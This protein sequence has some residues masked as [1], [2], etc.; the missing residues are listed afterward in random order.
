[1]K[2]STNMKT[3]T[4]L[5]VT[6]VLNFTLFGTDADAVSKVS[7]KNNVPKRAYLTFDDGNSP[8]THEILDILNKYE[9]EATFFVLAKNAHKET[10]ERIIN[11][12]H[13]LG[14]HGY[15]HKYSIY[16]NASTL[17]ED[18]RKANDIFM[19]TVGFRPIFFRPPYG[20]RK[21][22]N[23]E[24][25]KYIALNDQNYMYVYWNGDS[26]DAIISNISPE[27]IIK[28]SIYYIEKNPNDVVLLFHDG[29]GKENTARALPVILEYL[30][31][32][33][34]EIVGFD[35][36][37]NIKSVTY[38]ALDKNFEQRLKKLERVME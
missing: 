5:L 25:R 15:S 28:Y 20:E 23:S 4:M 31:Q 1:M 22:I 3:I 10:L 19:D 16:K 7:Q 8:I 2:K 29:L 34:Y 30:M 13:T 26:K 24:V 27:A 18:M 33:D 12:G 21:K 9:V 32:R 35:E 37:T 6:L 17:L 14:S 38:S 11:E 36:S